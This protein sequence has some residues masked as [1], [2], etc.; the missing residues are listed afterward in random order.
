MRRIAPLCLMIFTLAYLGCS[1]NPTS[2]ESQSESGIAA[3][4]P[5]KKP[6][7][8]E[9]TFD[10]REF[11][12]VQTGPG[13]IPLDAGVPGPY[14]PALLLMPDE[15]VM[16]IETWNWIYVHVVC[17]KPLDHISL[18]VAHDRIPDQ[19]HTRFSEYFFF[20]NVNGFMGEEWDQLP[21]NEYEYM[22]YLRRP[23]VGQRID[24]DGRN[25]FPDQIPLGTDP[26]NYNPL[27]PDADPYVFTMVAGLESGDSHLGLEL[28]SPSPER[29]AWVKGPAALHEVTVS[30][31]DLSFTENRYKERGKWYTEIVAVASFQ[32]SPDPYLDPN[33]IAFQWID[34]TGTVLTPALSSAGW[35]WNP[36]EGTNE[37]SATYN[38]VP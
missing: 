21:D 18:N 33:S 6:P 11:R 30:N 34:E 1:E 3:G 36:M 29:V 14:D 26:N 37:V 17:S 8:N 25:L 38:P 7:K 31:L 13:D 12:V 2:P 9:T 10:V 5:A 32:L 16:S 22:G 28:P 24:S 4:K 20:T 23:F 35:I 27:F 15:D 19:E